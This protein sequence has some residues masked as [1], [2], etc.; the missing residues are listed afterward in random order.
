[1]A[2]IAAA[3]AKRREMSLIT[4]SPGA[5]RRYRA[6]SDMGSAWPR[7]AEETLRPS[8][9]EDDRWPSRTLLYWFHRVRWPGVDA[10]FAWIPVLMLS[11]KEGEY[12]LADGWIGADD[13][14]TK[15]FSFVVPFGAPACPGTKSKSAVFGERSGHRSA[16][17]RSK[18]C[19]ESHTHARAFG[20]CLTAAT[21][22]VL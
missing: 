13:Y 5:V 7:G 4:S 18:R 17:R 22:I 3:I 15:P 14:L 2:E 10:S 20:G 1:M 8:I 12:D 11:A 9:A 21:S 16:S 19:G 6:T